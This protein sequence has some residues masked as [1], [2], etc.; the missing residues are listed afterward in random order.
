MSLP[1]RSWTSPLKSYLHNRKV[2]FHNFSGA[3]LNFGGVGCMESMFPVVN[4]KKAATCRWACSLIALVPSEGRRCWD[5][6]S[7]CQAW[8]SLSE[9]GDPNDMRSDAWTCWKDHFSIVGR[10][11]FPFGKH[12]FQVLLNVTFRGGGNLF[13]SRRMICWGTFAVCWF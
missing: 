4:H 12:H 3:I 8:F 7:K 5:F 6:S 10:Q 9:W 1:S 13:G 2:V 11:A